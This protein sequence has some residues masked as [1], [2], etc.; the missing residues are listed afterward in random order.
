[1]GN[2]A[3]FVSKQRFKD[4]AELLSFSETGREGHITQSDARQRAIRSAEIMITEDSFA[5]E[6]AAYLDS[7]RTIPN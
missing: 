5:R 3:F 1:M 7:L 4:G 6:F 2:A